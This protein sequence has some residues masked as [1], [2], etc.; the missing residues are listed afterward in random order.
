MRS[1][2]PVRV[3][4]WR[5]RLR[6]LPYVVALLVT[7]S[8]TSVPS[9]PARAQGVVPPP[10]DP[11]PP[12][13]PVDSVDE[14][15][16]QAR[17]KI[18]ITRERATGRVGFVRADRGGDLY[19]ESRA[20]PEVKANAYLEQYGDV[21]GAPIDQLVQTSVRADPLGTAVTFSQRYR[22]V[23]VFGSQI[24]VNFDDAGDMIAVNGFA[25]PDLDLSV[26][27]G[28]SRNEAATLA[29]AAVRA[30]PPQSEDGE[31]T[32]SLRGLRATEQ[33]LVIYRQGSLRGVPGDSLL[34]WRVVVSNRRE[35][36][37][38][39]FIAANSGKLLNRYST[40]PA[41]LDRQ[42]LNGNTV[43]WEEGQPFPGALSTEQQRVANA[44]ADTYWFFQNS[45]G[46]DSFDDDGGQ[47]TS[48][49]NP[50]GLVCPGANWDGNRTNFCS[51]VTSDDV[52]AHEWSH[53]YTET[54]SDL[55]YQYQSGALNEAYSDIWGETIDLINARD[56]DDEGDLTIKRT[57]GSCSTNTRAEP[58]LTITAPSTLARDCVAT[59]AL[60]GP[61]LTSTGTSGSVVSGVDVD[62]DGFGTASTNQ[63]GCSP[64]T[65][66]GSVAGKIV[67]LDR[68]GGC[69][70][71][72]K[73][74]NAQAAG[75]I[76]LVIVN[77]NDTL[78]ELT[79]TAP[80]ITIPSVLIGRSNG[81]AIRASLINGA[82][83]SGTLRDPWGPRQ[84]SYR[85]LV[86]EDVTNPG[87]AS[88]DLWTPTCLGD[89]GKVSD[90]EYYCASTDNGG[91][92]HNS[93][94]PAHAY[95]LLVD[96]GTY[97]GVPVVG[98][99]IDKAAA[100]HYRAQTNY[101]TRLSDFSDHAD[102]LRSACT[103]LIGQPISTL[104]TAANATTT[105]APTIT[106]TDC[107]SVI[108]VIAATEL[109]SAPTQC[110]TL[111]D[112]NAPAPCGDGRSRKLFFNENFTDGLAGWTAETSGG[113]P[114]GTNYPWVS[115]TSSG[116]SAAGAHTG[117][118]AYAQDTNHGNCSGGAGD[119][120]SR[121]AIISPP[122]VFNTT[123]VTDPRLTFDHY[124]ATEA[125]V[126]GGNVKIRLNG[127]AWQAVPNTAY[128]FN[129]M[130]STL[131]VAGNT[132]PLAGEE[133][134]T[135]T[136]GGVSTGS[137]GQS[138]IDLAFLELLPNDTIEIKLDF[139]RD[140]CF[141]IADGG[142]W[143]V[144]NVIVSVCR[145]KVR[146]TTT[147]VSQPS[148][149][150]D[151]STLRVSVARDG[152]TGS[153]PNGLLEVRNAAGATVGEGSLVD[154]KASIALPATMAVGSHPLTV[155]Y[156]GTPVF[157]YRTA[158]FTA[159]VAK[160]PSE[161]VARPTPKKPRFK[162][163]FAIKIAVSTDVTANGVVKVFKG[164]Q[165]L[166]KGT[167]TG[168]VATI[169]VKKNLKRGKYT[170]Q[171]EFVGSTTV[172]P[173]EDSFKIRIR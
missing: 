107:D 130:P 84:N 19:P 51:G 129:P 128:T 81:T 20:E 117:P 4:P 153:V 133:A 13:A 126:D 109:R 161:L 147:R 35:V 102:A 158:T 112:P 116:N 39:V 160:A 164:K 90:A 136:N 155:I 31:A 26:S 159:Q 65:N 21:F 11:A 63:D 38:Q 118:V 68:G 45:F 172:A 163:N 119:V 36:S 95:A 92:H 43:V 46:R 143:Y 56:D 7:A 87:G 73:A 40:M 24:N 55:V 77:N 57:M 125:G 66:A 70:S 1:H 96:G 97:N 72:T 144:D 89:P 62:E 145:A 104:T 34:T 9:A 127:G 12:S 59:A 152:T 132:N 148:T 54:D 154:G 50:P 83:V 17:G 100:I 42:I 8:L 23:P 88:R 171:A 76:A 78:Q 150:G 33:E 25:V 52:V 149:Y 113:V 79:G 115:R 91:V 170:L 58:V 28:L 82:A 110:G 67:L 124:V 60:F 41:A 162:A 135:G 98:I 6:P 86:G 75:A 80:A 106:A 103:A 85:W 10:D 44:A 5:A 121:D 64:L 71:V 16:D 151:P 47:M 120:T 2:G 37:E 157:E 29:V 123:A 108:A 74:T 30:D 27:P 69:T 137:W 173:S 101:L 122:I 134:F 18:R 166:G 15:T 32:R 53:A 111:L 141:G 61:S 139:G 156:A 140:G 3:M 142:G 48:A 105:P 114:S 169:K 14:I 22:G 93:A 167:V 94:I 146:M 131:E 99:G 168:G 165:L 49:L 138:Q